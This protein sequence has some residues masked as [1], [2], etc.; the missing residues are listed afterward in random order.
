M[1]RDASRIVAAPPDYGLPRSSARARRLAT[2]LI[3]F[4]L[5]WA[6][7]SASVARAEEAVAP[8]NT[9]PPRVSREGASEAITPTPAIE[10]IKLSATT[11]SWSGTEP[12]TY[13]YQWLSCTAEEE[14]CATIAGA[15][16]STFT[17][18]SAYLS[19]ALKVD[20]TAS[21]SAGS[22]TAAAWSSEVRGLGGDAVAFGVNSHTELGAGYK[23]THED[24][25]V[26]VIGLT[27]ITQALSSQEFS[28]L[29]LNN[30]TVRSFGDNDFSELGDGVAAREGENWING[31]SY[32]TVTGL[33]GE[34]SGVKSLASS[35]DHASAL[36]ENGTVKTWGD[37]FYGQIGNGTMGVSHARAAEVPGLSKVVAVAAGGGSNYALLSNH[38]VMAWGENTDG[39][40]GIG[41]AGGPVEDCHEGHPCEPTPHLV[42]APVLNEKGELVEIEKGNPEV[43]PLTHVAAI[44]AGEYAAYALLEDGHVMAWGNNLEGQLGDG[45]KEG[46]R[47]NLTPEEVKL[48]NGEPLTEVQSISAGAY[49]A[50]ALLKDGDVY[51]WGR[52][53]ALGEV[54]ETEKLEECAKSCMKAAVQIKGLEDVSEISGGKTYGLALIGGV[55]YGWGGNEQGQ[56][57]DGS[58]ARTDKPKRVTGIG[59]VAEVSANVATTPSHS[60]ALLAD[61]VKPPA[62]LLSIEPGPHSLDVTWNLT[63]PEYELRYK[64]W[65]TKDCEGVL[66]EGEEEGGTP[67]E[68]CELPEGA[69]WLGD[70][71]LG[72]VS[73]YELTELLGEV[74]YILSVKSHKGNGDHTTRYITGTPLP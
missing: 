67:E 12:I 62:P 74:P 55:I 31:K 10:G 30:G 15:T 36:L 70:F 42:G 38:T 34:L 27:G 28:L 40:L 68:E 6:A 7:A 61:G 59:S 63:L 39:H 2:V 29:L 8:T 51:G 41:E 52:A 60:L 56:L 48:R 65:N 46:V 53:D 24:A 37:N 33:S 18:T 72:D 47:V 64:V 71:K 54:E 32:V 13:S 22:A 73:G 25:P 17:P 43:T 35:N 57:G 14:G 50:L 49:F 21:N 23:D 3:A 44:T 1:S 58:V 9:V 20:V 4:A 19:R 26:Q 11:G 45:A 5:V 16:S 66:E 69:K